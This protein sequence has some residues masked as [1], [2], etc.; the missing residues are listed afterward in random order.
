MAP[1]TPPKS[2]QMPSRTCFCC[3]HPDCAPLKERRLCSRW[4]LI[5]WASSTK[6]T[7][8]NMIQELKQRLGDRRFSIQPVVWRSGV[9]EAFVRVELDVCDIVFV[10]RP[11]LL[12]LP[13]SRFFNVST[14]RSWP[15]YCCWQAIKGNV[16]Y[17]LAYFRSNETNV[18]LGETDLGQA[19]LEEIKSIV[20][21]TGGE[22]VMME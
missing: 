15:L 3:E 12:P 11:S 10:V 21:E 17:W 7:P 22:Q 18:T 19:L 20:G 4:Y 1:P 5:R 16:P 2:Q 8:L 14:S 13:G 9:Y 6:A